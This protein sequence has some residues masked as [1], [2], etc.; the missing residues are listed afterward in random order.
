MAGATIL[1]GSCPRRT[2]AFVTTSGDGTLTTI[3]DVDHS[4]IT[5]REAAPEDCRTV[6][7][8]VREI[9]AHQGQ[10]EH[11]TSDAAT[12]RSL[13]TR[14]E[15]TVLLAE[16]GGHPLGYVSAARR[17]HLWSGRDVV[18]LD[19]LY[20]RP[21]HRDR[22]V[23]RRLM[24]ELARRSDGHAITWGVQPGNHAALRFYERL[25]ASSYAK[26]M[27]VWPASEQR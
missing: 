23:G 8:L 5:I 17:L 24:D 9:A 1:V 15:V 27:C 11:V 25:G 7:M 21:S 10:S 6:E 14:P 18:A 4:G 20:V 2:H 13:L 16:E 19:D 22:G 26:V 12:W 3:A